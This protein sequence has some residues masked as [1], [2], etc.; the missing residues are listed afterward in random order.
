[1]QGPPD[2]VSYKFPNHAKT[3]AF[4]MPL[5]SSRDVPDPVTFSANLDPLEQRSLR[6]LHQK[7]GFR[8][9]STNGECPCG[10]SYKPIYQYATVDRKNI[11]KTQH[12][13][14]SEAMNDLIVNR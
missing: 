8:R 13:R 5:N 7:L 11:A 10:I 4:N 12:F 3:M 14:A 6:H 2:T 9:A 1:M